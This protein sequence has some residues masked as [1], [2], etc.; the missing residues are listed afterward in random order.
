MNFNLEKFVHLS[1]KRK[2][3]ITYTISDMTIPH[4]NSPKDL[5]LILSENLSWD[6]H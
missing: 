4:N 5:G 6:K 2:L 1:F 3:E